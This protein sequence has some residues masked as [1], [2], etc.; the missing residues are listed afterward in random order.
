VVGQLTKI[1][2]KRIDKIIYY[3]KLM[4][5]ACVICYNVL[6]NNRHLFRP[7]LSVSHLG[8]TDDCTCSLTFCR[9]TCRRCFEHWTSMNHTCIYCK[10]PIYVHF[11]SAMDV[12]YLSEAAMFVM[13]VIAFG[14]F[15]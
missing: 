11:I 1:G 14:A 7:M 4:T 9:T 6:S 2:P 5:N 15:G 12:I 13:A 3:Y 8:D 10:R